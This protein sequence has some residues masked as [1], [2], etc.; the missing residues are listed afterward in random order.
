MMTVTT[1]TTDSTKALQRYIEMNGCLDMKRIV[2]NR[3]KNVPGD[4]N[5]VQCFCFSLWGQSIPASS[6]SFSNSNLLFSS[7]MG[8]LAN[9][10][11][12]ILCE[13]DCSLQVKRWYSKKYILCMSEGSS[14]KAS[15]DS[16]RLGN[17]ATLFSSLKKTPLLYLKWESQHSQVR[18]CSY[19][20][21]MKN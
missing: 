4:N 15:A 3:T 1:K 9:L 2:I 20:T 19:D 18:M 7:L 17:L 8:L 11:I 16:R 6:N 10:L 13:S 14:P 12:L 5:A 21:A